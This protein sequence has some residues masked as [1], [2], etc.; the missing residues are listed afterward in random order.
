MDV[1][2]KIPAIV[3]QRTQRR[4]QGAL[5]KQSLLG[6]SLLN[7][8]LCMTRDWTIRVAVSIRVG[9]TMIKYAYRIL[10]CGEG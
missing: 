6:V 4:L 3:W 5:V 8:L 7:L 1:P 9:I 10:F 2:N